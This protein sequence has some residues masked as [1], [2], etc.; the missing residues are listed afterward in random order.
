MNKKLLIL[1]HARHGKDTIAEFIEILCG[2]THTS[3]SV[4][5]L[6]VFL[7]D[8]LEEKYGL[9]YKDK[10]EAFEDRVNQ[11]SR[12]FDEISLYNKEDPARLAKEIMA[13]HDI[14]V[15]L[16][17]SIEVEKCIEDN[18]F[19]FIIGVYDYRKPHEST[20]SNDADVMKYSD[21]VITNNSNLSD[22]MKKVRNVK[23][24]LNL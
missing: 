19:D 22:L 9:V 7:L 14:Y 10:M 12:W 13:E 3:S 20:D 23:I 4:K 2:Y 6:D 1:G 21:V 18:V 15:G 11:R 16:R 24:M 17:S 8:V 5:A